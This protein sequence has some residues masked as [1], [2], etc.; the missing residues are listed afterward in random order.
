MPS[1]SSMPL[2]HLT[3]A[4]HRTGN[5][6]LYT[7]CANINTREHELVN[8]FCFDDGSNMNHIPGNV[9]FKG[10]NKIRT[11]YYSETYSN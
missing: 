11:L 2:E 7:P 4:L 8:T 1:F 6:T 3:R 5:V 10:Y 9:S